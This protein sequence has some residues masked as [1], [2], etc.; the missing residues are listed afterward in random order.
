MEGIIMYRKFMIFLVSIFIVAGTVPEAFAGAFDHS[1][2]DRV[3]KAYV[4][5]EN[6]QAMLEE[7]T[8][9]YL[10]SQR[11]LRIDIAANT[12]Y[13][14]KIFNFYSIAKLLSSPCK[15]CQGK[16]VIIFERHEAKIDKIHFCF[17]FINRDT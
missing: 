12:L 1:N 5:E 2:F 16:A 10:N 9:N 15:Y 3:L 4:T 14:S 11:G 7:E 17:K 8:R 6:V 13:L